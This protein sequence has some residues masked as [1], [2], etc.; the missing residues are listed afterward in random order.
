MCRNCP[1][2]TIYHVKLSPCNYNLMAWVVG[3]IGL[4]RGFLV[5]M[6]SWQ[7]VGSSVSVISNSPLRL[8]YCLQCPCISFI[9]YSSVFSPKKFDG[10]A[11]CFLSPHVTL[12]SVLGP[13]DQRWRLFHG[14]LCIG[15]KF[16]KTL[17]R[18]EWHVRSDPADKVRFPLAVLP[19]LCFGPPH[20]AEIILFR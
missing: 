16:N 20:P 9:F 8:Y 19:T 11:I 15:Q 18:T 12:S 6:D 1:L 7:G 2:C 17:N 5:C 10:F 14:F 4:F 13:H 3:W